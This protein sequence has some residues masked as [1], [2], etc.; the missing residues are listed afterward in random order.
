MSSLLLRLSEKVGRNQT[1]VFYLVFCVDCF[2]MHHA[3]FFVSE[4]PVKEDAPLIQ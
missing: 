1:S 2:E 4:S 3:Y